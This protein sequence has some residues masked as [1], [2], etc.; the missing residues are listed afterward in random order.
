MQEKQLTFSEQVA[1]AVENGDRQRVAELYREHRSP[2]LAYSGYREHLSAE[3]LDASNVAAQ[4]D[5]QKF[6][7]DILLEVLSVQSMLLHRVGESIKIAIQEH[8][9]LDGGGMPW[10]WLP[11]KVAEEMLPRYGR[12]ASEVAGTI[13]LLRKL[14][15]P[16]TS[17]KQADTDA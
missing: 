2:R 9:Q 16:A 8:D 17:S 1:M 6:Q 15:A 3:I 4:K 13:K 7:R 10:G 5:P 11:P 14:E 12:V